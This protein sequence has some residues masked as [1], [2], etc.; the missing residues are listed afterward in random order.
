MVTMKPDLRTTL[1]WTTRITL[2]LSGISLAFML[3]AYGH[4]ELTSPEARLAVAAFSG[5][6]ALIGGTLMW[7]GLPADPNAT[8][9]KA[10]KRH[11]K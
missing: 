7:V 2:T 10:R 5:L 6:M 9:T 11:G 4:T 8:T 1:L 3:F